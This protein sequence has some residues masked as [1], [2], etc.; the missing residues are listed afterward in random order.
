MKRKICLVVWILFVPFTLLAQID[1]EMKEFEDFVKQQQKEFDD[2]VDEQNKEFAKFLKETWKEYNLEQ[3]VARPVRPEPVKPVHFDKKKPIDKPSEIKVGEVIRMPIPEV[4]PSAAFPTDRKKTPVPTIAGGKTPTAK[5]YEKPEVPAARPQKPATKPKTPVVTPQKPVAKPKSPDKPK[6]IPDDT[7]V[8]KQPESPRDE[9]ENKRDEDAMPIA[10]APKAVRSGIQFSFYGEECVVN[11]SLKNSLRLRG[12]AEKD[13]ADGWETLARSQ[14]QTLIEDCLA[15]KAECGLND[16]GY[17]LLTRKVAAELCGGRV[18]NDSALLQMFIL[19]QSG[20]KAKVA[21]VGNQLELFYASDDMIYSVSYIT[22]SGV[23]YYKLNASSGRNEAIYTYNK[24][25]ANSRNTVSMSIASPQLFAGNVKKK[26]LQA[27]A[28]PAAKVDS[29]VSSDLI[30]FYKDYP[31]C[32]FSV[33]AGAPVS[34][35]IQMTVLPPLRTA[36][37]GKKQS[38]AANILINFVQTAFEYQTDD[39]QFGY[40]KPFFV[41]ELF[42]YPYSDC[43]DRSVLFAYLVKKLIGLDVVFLDYPE[44]IATAVHFNEEVGGDYLMVNGKKYTVCDPT[45][46]GATIGMTMPQFKNISAKV[47]KY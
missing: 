11:A 32:D 15:V 44:H 30:S 9:P 20:Y 38:E 42:Y 33:Y 34:D 5:P 22:L 45:Y 27:K 26:S 16:Y 6:N 12:I 39:D 19:C 18:G 29:Q 4:T 21:R 24:D 47:L 2:F 25:F 31:Q 13:I 36:I 7:S 41:E 46:I 8:G 43:E 17:L 10:P 3:P 37:Q 35:E 23:K 1:K 40:E 28:Y 14:Y